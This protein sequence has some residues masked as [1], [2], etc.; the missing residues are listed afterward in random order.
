MSLLVSLQASIYSR[1]ECRWP[2]K[3]AKICWTLSYN[4]QGYSKYLSNFFF[5]WLL[6]SHQRCCQ[7]A[8]RKKLR[9][10]CPDERKAVV[11]NIL[12]VMT[13]CAISE[14]WVIRPYL[15]ENE[16]VT[17]ESCQNMLVYGAFPPF[18]WPQE[19]YIFQ[20]AGAPPHYSHQ[21]TNHLNN[22]RPSNLTGKGGPL[23]WPARSPDLTPCHFFLCSLIKSTIYFPP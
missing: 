5:G 8:R 2:T 3:T 13:R 4:A 21:A 12:G 20:Q 16:N 14:E 11:M 9:V 17:G 1:I 23:G 19:D 6:V 10:D 22:K 15:F 7:Q 18:R